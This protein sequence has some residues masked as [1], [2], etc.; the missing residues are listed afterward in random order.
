M[1]YVRWSVLHYIPN[2]CRIVSTLVAFYSVYIRSFPFY[3]FILRGI[4]RKSLHIHN[5]CVYSALYIQIFVLS[6]DVLS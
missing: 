6:V 5:V 4:C 3:V 2:Y 1:Q